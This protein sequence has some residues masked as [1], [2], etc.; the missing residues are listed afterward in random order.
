[1]FACKARSLL[2]IFML[3]MSVPYETFMHTDTHCI[4]A[5]Q[6]WEQKDQKSL[7]ALAGQGLRGRNVQDWSTRAL[8]NEHGELQRE[9][10]LWC[11][12]SIIHLIAI[13]EPLFWREREAARTVVE[14][15][16]CI[17]PPPF[18]MFLMSKR[19]K[20]THATQ[21][22]CLP[23][24]LSLQVC[25]LDTNS[26]KA[27]GYMAHK[28]KKIPK[29]KIVSQTTVHSNIFFKNVARAPGIKYF[30]FISLI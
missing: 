19:S 20:A 11:G 18:F 12:G 30:R 23:T 24:L 21:G 27:L 13:C 14:C 26:D 22:L 6:C 9:S 15:W 5:G 7:R 29:P 1:M 25:S 8:G 10:L 17:V 4:M 16:Q 2:L 28:R 3:H